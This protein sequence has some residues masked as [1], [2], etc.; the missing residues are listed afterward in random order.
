M[1]LLGTLLDRGITVVTLEDGQ[2]YSAESVRSGSLQLIVAVVKMQSAYEFSARLSRRMHEAWE[3]KRRGIGE[4]RLTRWCPAWLRL[5]DDR[6]SY[7]LIEERAAVVRRIFDL[8]ANH[9]HGKELI[10]KTLNYEGMPT[11]QPM[12][13]PG[14]KRRRAE[15]WAIGYVSRILKN[16]AVIGE[17]TPQITGEK[18]G[19]RTNSAV[20]EPIPDYF[21]ATIERAV[22][23]RAEAVRQNRMKTGGPKGE[24]VNVFTGLLVC[25]NCLRPMN[26][27]SKGDRRGNVG[28]RAGRYLVCS[29]AVRR[30]PGEGG[31]WLCEARDHLPYFPFEDAVLD[32]I[33]DLLLDNESTSDER[34]RGIETEIGR[35][36]DEIAGKRK[37]LDRAVT[38]LGDDDPE[39]VQSI[40]RNRAAIEAGKKRLEVLR[41]NLEAARG[42]TP[43][44]SGMELIRTLRAEANS[45]DIAV[46]RN[47]RLR[48]AGALRAIVERIVVH[49][50]AE[51]TV[52]LAGG[53]L[54]VRLDGVVARYD[55]ESGTYRAE[56]GGL[57]MSVDVPDDYRAEMAATAAQGIGA[58]TSIARRIASV[59]QTRRARREAVG[60]II[61]EIVGT[62]RTVAG[63]ATDR[64][65]AM[66][67]AIKGIVEECDQD[68]EIGT[69]RA[70]LATI[71]FHTVDEALVPAD[72][73]L[74]AFGMDQDS[75]DEFKRVFHEALID[76]PLTRHAPDTLPEVMPI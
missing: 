44:R 14:G 39:I 34:T 70:K 8:Y 72:A 57:E 2:T 40:A 56:L 12:Q 37:S 31:H 27:R 51:T 25:C 16:R 68:T 32:V 55:A 24:V 43:H 23:D 53:L 26:I 15:G 9:E 1:R 49:A 10:A 46:R 52:V 64:R 41:R 33:G 71:A 7:V 5:S 35:L 42:A 4:I 50:S 76:G 22:W 21:P 28:W 6:R 13:P 38:L 36:T 66:L 45:P 54:L 48:I 63:G 69:L 60:T 58:A 18:D 19:K 20:R 3:V 29:N 11:W 59:Q 62:V 75:L 73:I 17:F 61:D 65:V 67:T 74:D 30:V 47:A